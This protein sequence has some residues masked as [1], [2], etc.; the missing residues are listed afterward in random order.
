MS[1]LSVRG[2]ER[3][4]AGTSQ[5]FGVGMTGVGVARV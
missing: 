5:V 3:K 4:K 1:R 2:G